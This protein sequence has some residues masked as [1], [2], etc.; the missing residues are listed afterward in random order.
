MFRDEVSDQP[1]IA[2]EQLVVAFRGALANALRKERRSWHADWVEQLDPTAMRQLISA[3]ARRPK[4]SIADV[5]QAESSRDAAIRSAPAVAGKRID[6]RR[7]AELRHATSLSQAELAAR[8]RKHGFATNQATVCRW[9]TGRQP[10]GYIHA[11]LAQ[12]LN[13]DVDELTGE[14]K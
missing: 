8:L 14:A 11:A 13:V 5:L 1:T 9:E 12:A 7:I 10:S 6:G 2:A 4:A 3:V